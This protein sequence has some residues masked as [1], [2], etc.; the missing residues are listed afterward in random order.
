M[1]ARDLHHLRAVRRTAG[2]RADHLR[3][4]AEKLRADQMP[5]PVEPALSLSNGDAESVPR[6]FNRPCGT[7]RTAG[8][9]PGTDVLG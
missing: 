1:P 6:R 5:S 8:R 3:R 7:S 4:F 2:R 9:A